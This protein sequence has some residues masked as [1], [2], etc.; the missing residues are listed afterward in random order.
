[1]S[2]ED[3][4]KY[5]TG[6]MFMLATIAVVYKFLQGHDGIEIVNM[7]YFAMGLGGLFVTRKAVSYFKPEQY[8]TQGGVNESKPKAPESS[9]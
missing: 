5:V 8:Y 7:T 1:M 6:T 3:F 4:E 9:N 2:K